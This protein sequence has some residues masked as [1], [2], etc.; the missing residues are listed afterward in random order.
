MLL[1]EIL[2]TALRCTPV[3]LTYKRSWVLNGMVAVKGLSWLQATMPVIQFS[4]GS[5][6]SVEYLTQELLLLTKKSWLSAYSS[7]LNFT[8]TATQQKG[9]CCI[10]LY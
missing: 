2:S 10:T 4:P 5:I 3:T 1:A 6:Y 9:Y 8:F 7:Q